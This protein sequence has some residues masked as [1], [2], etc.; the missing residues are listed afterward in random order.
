MLKLPPQTGRFPAREWRAHIALLTSIL[1]SMAFMFFAT[2]LVGVLWL[3]TWPV[4]T[5]EMRI[6]ILGKA[7]MLSLIGSLIV[8]ISFGFAINRRMVK[9][10]RNGFEAEGGDG[11]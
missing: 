10:T 5:A 4:E 3:G 1:G 7:L 6:E 11:D 2:A 9:L 8:V